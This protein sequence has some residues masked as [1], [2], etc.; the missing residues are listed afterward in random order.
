[1]FIFGGVLPFFIGMYRFRSEAEM[2]LQWRRRWS[3]EVLRFMRLPI[4]EPRTR[5]LINN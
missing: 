2:L 5:G 1:M 3:Q 4:G